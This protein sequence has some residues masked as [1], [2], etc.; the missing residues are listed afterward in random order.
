MNLLPYFQWCY[1]TALGETIRESTWLFPAIESTHLLALA[2][3]GGAILI[4]S[5]SILGWG[6]KTPVADIYRSAHRYLNTAIV[7]LLIYNWVMHQVRD[8]HA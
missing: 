8:H 3:L 4:M 1:D 7:V 2:L 6:L 5:L